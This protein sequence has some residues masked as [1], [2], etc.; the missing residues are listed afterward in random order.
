MS[1]KKEILNKIK[2]VLTQQFKSPEDA[3]SFFDKNSDGVLNRK[4]VKKLLKKSKVNSFLHGVVSKELLKK[5]DGDKSQTIA[6]S[7]FKKAVKDIA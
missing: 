6:W 1:K 2:I 5:F 4:E 3:F 7:E